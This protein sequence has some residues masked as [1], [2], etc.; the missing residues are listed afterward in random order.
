MYE[1]LQ[2][3]LSCISSDLD[4]DLAKKCDDAGMGF[5]AMKALAGGLITNTKAAYAAL[6]QYDYVIP[7]WGIQHEW[8]L[9]EFIEYEKNP[10]ILD[11]SLRADIAKDRET[12][13]GSFC[14][15]CGYCM[16]CPVSIPIPMAARLS[17]MMGR[18]RFESFLQDDW[19]SQMERIN[20]CIQCG[21]CIA[22]CPYSL[23]TPTLLKEQ[24]A[25]YIEFKKT[26]T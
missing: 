24:L 20:D 11:E 18:A 7:I 6:R 23:D 26:H 16:P 12:L 22:Q 3:P 1:S 4:F 14:R 15:G 10:P 8:E 9:D 25:K 5:I 17:Y 19:A 21:K 13:S 2:F